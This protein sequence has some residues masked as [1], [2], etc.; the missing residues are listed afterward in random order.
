MY[1]RVRHSRTTCRMNHFLGF[2]Y[3]NI[4]ILLFVS[5]CR[6]YQSWLIMFCWCVLEH[7]S[8]DCSGHTLLYCNTTANCL[9]CV[10]GVMQRLDESSAEVSTHMSSHVHLQS[11]MMVH[12]LPRWPCYFFL[13]I[14]CCWAIRVCVWWN[15]TFRGSRL[16]GPCAKLYWFW[17]GFHFIL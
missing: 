1:Y 16:A 3:M 4:Y 10:C 6:P 5:S 12:M 13:R 8:L 11:F 14:W 15:K 17:S 2:F 9:F 7:S